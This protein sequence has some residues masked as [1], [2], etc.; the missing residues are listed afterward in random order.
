LQSAVE[1][2][3][4]IIV[5]SGPGFASFIRSHVPMLSNV[6]GSFFSSGSKIRDSERTP[7]KTNGKYA[8]SDRS[9]EQDFPQKSS[10]DR[11]LRFYELNDTWMLKS[12][13][14]A[15]DTRIENKDGGIMRTIAFEQ[16]VKTTTSMEKLVK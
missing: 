12:G 10:Q 15:E 6:A 5:S 8:N 14:A 9:S 1:L 11:S 16:Q 4:A 7:A 2:N 13:A 3:V